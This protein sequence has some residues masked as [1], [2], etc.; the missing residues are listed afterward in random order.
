MVK[1]TV[2]FGPKPLSGHIFLNMRQIVTEP[3]V[4]A[5]TRLAIIR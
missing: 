2:I 3:F 1:H 4:I 5:K